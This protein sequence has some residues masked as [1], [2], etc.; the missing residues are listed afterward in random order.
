M[1]LLLLGSLFL[2]AVI[3]FYARCIRHGLNI[4]DKCA[5]CQRNQATRLISNDQIC[6]ECFWLGRHR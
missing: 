6:E 5:W 1:I 3:V 2:A 4:A